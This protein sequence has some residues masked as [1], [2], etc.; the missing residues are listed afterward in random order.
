MSIW[1]PTF[2]SR[3]AAYR[4]TQTLVK[5]NEINSWKKVNLMLDD[6]LGVPGEFKCF[7]DLTFLR[8]LIDTPPAQEQGSSIPLRT[9]V[10]FMDDHKCNRL[11]AGDRIKCLS[12]PTSGVFQIKR[13]P[14]R[15]PNVVT[16]AISHIEVQVFEI[17]G[18]QLEAYPDDI[19]G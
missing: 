7:L 16:G 13:V 3:V 5:G 9:G 10:M 19:E 4:L 12:G 6:N 11:E 1:Y 8:A 14:D 2:H 17:S 18:S 15:L